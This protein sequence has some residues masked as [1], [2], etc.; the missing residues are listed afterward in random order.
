M[1]THLAQR[2]PLLWGS[3]END[4]ISFFTHSSYSIE[5][6]F[7]DIWQHSASPC[8]S[9]CFATTWW[10]SLKESRS[11][12]HLFL[13]VGWSLLKAGCYLRIL[14]LNCQTCQNH[15]HKKLS[16]P[17]AKILLLVHSFL[18]NLDHCLPCPAVSVTHYLTHIEGKSLKKSYKLPTTNY[19]F[20]LRTCW[21]KKRQE[22]FWGPEVARLGGLI[23]QSVLF[24]FTW[25]YNPS[26]TH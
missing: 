16:H 20:K 21:G 26:L 17:M 1:E 14:S 10:H 24:P 3:C 11:I 18:S 6:T 9:K 2:L 12:L 5:G 13:L 19:S 4:T 23:P 22:I 7:H 25:V 15:C 8:V